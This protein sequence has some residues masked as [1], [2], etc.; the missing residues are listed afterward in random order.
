MAEPELVESLGA[1]VRTASDDAVVRIN[2]LRYRGGAGARHR[3]RRQAVPARAQGW[4]AHDGV[5]V[6]LPRLRRDRGAARLAHLGHRA[7]LLPDLQRRSRSRAERLHRDR[8]QRLAGGPPLA[9]PRA[10]QPRAGGVLLP[11][12]LHAERR[13]R[14]RHAYPRVS[15]S[16]GAGDRLH[17][18]GRDRDLLGD[19]RAALPLAHQRAGADRRRRPHG[20][21]ADVRVRVHRDAQQGLPRGDRRR[22]RRDRVH[23]RDRRA[24]PA[25]DHEPAGSVRGDDAAV[26]LRR[27]GAVE[28]DVP[29]PVRRRDD[30]RRRGPGGAEPRPALHRP[31]GID[32]ALRADRRHEGIRPRPPALRLPA[33]VHRAQLGRAR[34]DDRRR[35]HGELRRPARR[36]ALRPRHAGGDRALQRGGRRP[37]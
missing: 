12:P 10:A 27:R 32:G 31:A 5:A 20:R 22:P 30:R 26:P 33:R 7:L 17:R 36:P 25:R 28:P 2:A 1:F 14:R 11:L 34:E 21:D 29:R 18:A 24:V 4:T 8:L 13:G 3:R 37:T 35:G 9:L 16:R 23:E 15:A 6:R 19:R